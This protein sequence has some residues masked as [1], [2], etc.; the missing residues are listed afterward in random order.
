MGRFITAKEAM[1]QV[2]HSITLKNKVYKWILEASSRGLCGIRVYISNYGDSV[3]DRVSN[4]LVED[5]YHVHISNYIMYITWCDCKSDE[6]VEQRELYIAN[7][8]ES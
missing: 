7:Y 2:E 5:G 4:S 6:E 8:K 3:V 1:Q